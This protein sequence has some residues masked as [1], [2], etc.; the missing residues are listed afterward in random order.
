MNLTTLT[1]SH[2]GLVEFP[3]CLLA[4][5]NLVTLDLSHNKI[6]T[7][8]DDDSVVGAR[9][10][11]EAWDKE[12]EEL[13]SGGIWAGLTQDEPKK[14]KSNGQPKLDDSQSPR[15]SPMASLRTL[16]L[17]SNRLSNVALG[18]APPNAQQTA[19]LTLPYQLRK[20][21]LS[22]NRLRSPLTTG[23]FTSTP[24]LA[25]LELAG[26]SLIDDVFAVTATAAPTEDHSSVQ[27]FANLQTLDLQRCELDDLTQLEAFFGSRRTVN[28]LG[29][30]VQAS[31]EEPKEASQDGAIAPRQLV[32][33][34]DKPSPSDLQE[35]EKATKPVL[36]LLVEG[37]PLREEIARQKRGFART[38]PVKPS[39]LDQEAHTGGSSSG[40]TASEDQKDPSSS[41]HSAAT[42]TTPVKQG[43]VKEEWE[44]QAEL[45]L[46]TEGGRRRLRAEQARKEREAQA[47][48]GIEDET[49]STPP[50]SRS[51]QRGT[52]ARRGV[53]TTGLSD[54]DGEPVLPRRSRNGAP[55]QAQQLSDDEGEGGSALASTKLSSKKK[56]ALSQVPCKFFRANGCTAGKACPFSHTLPEPGQQ[57]AV[58]QWF[59]KGSCRFGHKCALAHVLPGQPMSVSINP[60]FLSWVELRV[61]Q[62]G[63][64]T[65]A[66]QMRLII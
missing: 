59:M 45:G 12:Q 7:L 60:L 31:D 25:E 58:C 39:A 65:C 13:H 6:Q 61:A 53:N 16:D 18:M 35:V 52:P 26:N 49:E 21:I 10:Q 2:N 54:W 36:C 55:S 30:G 5:D 64:R 56:E 32:R 44:I 43:I 9:E 57:K 41:D 24:K 3:S 29:E 17:S 46:L 20:L 66:D 38:A 1:L 15:S 14:S 8:W 51:G 28:T 37:N 62:V 48:A 4:L 27:V 63:Y 22:D 23:A 40:E 19:K 47:T 33:F 11:R 42:P 50:R 34:T